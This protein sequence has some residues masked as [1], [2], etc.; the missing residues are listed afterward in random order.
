M[1]DLDRRAELKYIREAQI[2]PWTALALEQRVDL[3]PESAY[4]YVEMGMIDEIPYIS[5]VGARATIEDVRAYVAAPTVVAKK[6]VATE[7]LYRETGIVSAEGYSMA[8]VPLTGV[9]SALVSR[10]PLIITILKGLGYLA[11]AEE[12]YEMITG[13]SGLFTVDDVVQSWI[14]SRSAFVPALPGGGEQVAMGVS[15]DPSDYKVGQTREG[16]IISKV[17]KFDFGKPYKVNAWK[18][19][20]GQGQYN[21]LN[22]KERCAY[23]LGIRVQTVTG[24]EAKYRAYRRGFDDGAHAQQEAERSHEGGTTPLQVYSRSRGR[25]R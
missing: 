24:R 10:I 25:R 17:T 7:V 23:Y 22:F 15:G 8:I 20:E 12:L 14:A 2:A 1:S 6:A 4:T 13:T 16:W 18:K 21:R 11:L 3:S 5:Q 19:G 9:M